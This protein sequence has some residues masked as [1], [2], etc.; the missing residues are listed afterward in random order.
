MRAGVGDEVGDAVHRKIVVDHHHQWDAGHAGHR[1]DRLGEIELDGLVEGGVDGV[2]RAG[3]KQRVAIGLGVDHGLGADIAAGAG[4]VLHHEGIAQPLGQALADQ[5][6][7]HVRRSS[8][9]IGNHPPNRMEGV[10]DG[11]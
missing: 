3:E 8:G 7:Q 10:G 9:G 11:G 5:P 2:G 4:L 1:H 6:R